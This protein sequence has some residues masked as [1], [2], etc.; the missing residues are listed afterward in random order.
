MFLLTFFVVYDIIYPAKARRSAI[1]V[2]LLPFS[3]EAEIFFAFLDKEGGDD[4][5]HYVGSTFPFLHAL[6]CNHQSC[7]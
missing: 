3:E 5:V 4:N 6:S 2:R 1:S 7:N